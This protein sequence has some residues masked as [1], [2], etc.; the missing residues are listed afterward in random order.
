MIMK[1]DFILEEYLDQ[2]DRCISTN[3]GGYDINIIDIKYY[4]N[5]I[6]PLE[7]SKVLILTPSNCI[8]AQLKKHNT[9]HLADYCL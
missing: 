4:R 9:Q 6:W 1:F 5:I 8:I 2:M 7:W 3:I